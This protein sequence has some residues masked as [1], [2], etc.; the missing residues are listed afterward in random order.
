MAALSEDLEN[1][2]LRR[3]AFAA[4]LALGAV[5][6]SPLSAA[7]APYEFAP[8]PQNDL[9][10]LYRVDRATGEV[11][12]CQFQLKEGGVG[13]TICFPAGEGAGPQPPSDYLLVPSRH[14]REGGIFRVN[15]RTGEMSV[16]YVFDD[17]VVCTPQA[18]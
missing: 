14:E 3:P 5:L 9:N 4:L 15:L 16:C 10:R 17:K 7:A 2:G 8:A 18:R 6:A 13:V 11:G 12:A 1:A